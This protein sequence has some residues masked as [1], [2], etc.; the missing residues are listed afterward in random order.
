MPTKSIGTGQYYD[1]HRMLNAQFVAEPIDTRDLQTASRRD[2]PR[3]RTPPEGL[4]CRFRPSPGRHPPSRAPSPPL[5]TRNYHRTGE[6]NSRFGRGLGAKPHVLRGLRNSARR[7]TTVRPQFLEI[8]LQS[9]AQHRRRNCRRRYRLSP[10]YRLGGPERRAVSVPDAVRVVMSG[11]CGERDDRTV[12]SAHSSRLSLK[13]QLAA[14]E[15]IW[16]TTSVVQT[17][18]GDIRRVV[19]TAKS[20]QKS[21]GAHWPCSIR[22]HVYRAG[23]RNA[24]NSRS[25]NTSSDR[26]VLPSL[27]PHAMPAPENRCL[28]TP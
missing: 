4:R 6:D 20:L 25:W 1:A 10:S 8:A 7:R 9:L 12:E 23:R 11:D 21:V 16:P 17:H 3:Q 5:Q 18:S 27:R 14:V 26:L 24:P 28:E 15:M 2:Q 22:Q 19:T 13:E